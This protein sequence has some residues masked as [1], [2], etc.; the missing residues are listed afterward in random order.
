MET[1]VTTYRAL[2]AGDLAH[3]LF[4]LRLSSGRGRYHFSLPPRRG[5]D[6]LR[7]DLLSQ[8]QMLQGQMQW[9]SLWGNDF[10]SVWSLRATCSDSSAI[11]AF[12]VSSGTDFCLGGAGLTQDCPAAGGHTGAASCRV[13]DKHLLIWK[14]QRQKQSAMNHHAHMA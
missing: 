5:E 2:S 1:L 10:V 14:S 11:V 9:G 7:D 13:K 3:I 8:G 4:K 12:G 6:S